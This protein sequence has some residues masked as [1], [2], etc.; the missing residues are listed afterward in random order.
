MRLGVSGCAVGADK[1]KIG[2]RHT[3]G[4]T[5]SPFFVSPDSLLRHAVIIGASGTGKSAL[6]GNI[7]ASLISQNHGV[8]I[9]DPH[10]SFAE[11]VLR[12]CPKRRTDDI[13]FF[14]PAGETDRPIGINPLSGVAP[15]AHHLA[16]DA[17]VDALRNIYGNSWGPRLE[18]LLYASTRAILTFPG[19]T[20]LHIN[21]LLT[22]QSFRD[23]VVSKISDRTIR[24][25]WEDEFA[26]YDR[27]FRSEV[28]SP[29]LNKL[30]IG[31]PILRLVLGQ[32]R[33][34]IKVRAVLDDRKIFIANLSGLG[35][36]SR[37]LLGS[38]IISW[39][40]TAALSRKAG[41]S[42]PPFFLFTDEW[43]S[44]SSRSFISL[45]S[46]AR[47]FSLGAVL[48]GQLT[49]A[50]EEVRKAALS[51]CATTVA[52]RLSGEDAGFIERHFDSVYPPSAFTDLPRFQGIIKTEGEDPFKMTSLPPAS[53][54][55]DRVGVI[56]DV[57]RRKYGRERHVIE[58][59]ASIKGK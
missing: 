13:I 45:L 56:K 10:D 5:R 46:E 48:I 35:T 12:Y 2:L 39:F 27:R 11:A 15:E 9:V 50:P 55:H 4:G 33:S 19:G 17:V 6:A 42:N 34:K 52:F 1:I 20:I 28:S 18:R 43:Q 51:N 41:E 32:R 58:K 16:A 40:Q 25:F 37:D 38:L 26:T 7:A 23:R 31:D 29:V 30:M 14:N 57:S 49:Q 24:S 8:A 53:P 22:N 54:L 36:T 59:K 47:K 21:K 3:Y 44:I